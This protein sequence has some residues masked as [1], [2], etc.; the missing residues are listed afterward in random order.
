MYQGVLPCTPSYR[1]VRARLVPGILPR[2]SAWFVPTIRSYHE[3]TLLLNVAS[4]RR[5]AR[6]ASRS[7]FQVALRHMYAQSTWMLLI[8]Q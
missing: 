6:A 4:A 8:Y 2:S 1:K 3:L 7:V 5:S